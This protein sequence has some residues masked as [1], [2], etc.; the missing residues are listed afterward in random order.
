MIVTYVYLDGTFEKRGP[1]LAA[2]YQ[3]QRKRQVREC[4]LTPAELDAAIEPSARAAIEHH[5]NTNPSSAAAL[6]GL[7]RM[8]EPTSRHIEIFT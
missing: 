8:T 3:K 6:A 4:D 7:V 5:Q 1:G 2:R